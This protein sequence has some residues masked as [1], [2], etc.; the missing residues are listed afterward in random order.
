MILLFTITFSINLYFMIVLT[1]ILIIVLN[2]ILVNFFLLDRFNNM[3]NNEKRTLLLN[4]KQHDTFI[5]FGIVLI[6]LFKN[7]IYDARKFNYI[8]KKGNDIK[9]AISMWGGTER[10]DELLNIERKIKLL[11]LKYSK[12]SFVI[13]KVFS[14]FV[15][16]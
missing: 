8:N 12:K 1:G 16:Q 11:K 2:I 15:E 6:P 14:I 5:L 10:K 4:Q 9:Y 13:R 3:T 7:T